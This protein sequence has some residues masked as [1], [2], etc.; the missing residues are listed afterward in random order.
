[1]NSVF[2]VQHSYQTGEDDL[3]KNKIIGIYSSRQNAEKTI[4]RL[5]T[6]EGFRD[7]PEGFEIEEYYLDRTLWEGGFFTI[8]LEE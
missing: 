6:N 7:H 3:E 8:D 5:S 4:A 2:F 1:M